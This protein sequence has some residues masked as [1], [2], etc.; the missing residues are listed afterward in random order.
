MGH[1]KPKGTWR[2]VEKGQIAQKEQSIVK[3]IAWPMNTHSANSTVLA[4]GSSGLLKA[5]FAL[6]F[7]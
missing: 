4:P 3:S 5:L 7:Y 1:V 2:I 6:T